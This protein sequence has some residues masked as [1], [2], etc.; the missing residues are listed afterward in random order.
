[1]SPSHQLL[2][3]KTLFWGLRPAA[4][5][6]STGLIFHYSQERLRLFAWTP[7]SPLGALGSRTFLLFQIEGERRP[8][9]PRLAFL[10]P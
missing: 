9:L 7:A 6:P 4:S 10:S 3:P 1:M 2:K 8:Q 5:L